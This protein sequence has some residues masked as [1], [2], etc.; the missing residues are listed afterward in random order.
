M[1]DGELLYTE[2]LEV[3]L[4]A[5]ANRLFHDDF[6]RISVYLSFYAVSAMGT[7]SQVSI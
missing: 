6:S 3:K 7:K 4:F 5:F 1:L 2:V